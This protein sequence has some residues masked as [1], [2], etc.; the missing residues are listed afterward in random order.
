VRS[1]L[2]LGENESSRTNII[3]TGTAMHIADVG[4]TFNID[5]QLSFVVK[6]IT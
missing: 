2:A 3:Y 6:A 4:I 1:I 5:Y